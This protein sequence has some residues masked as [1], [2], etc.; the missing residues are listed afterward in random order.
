M[1]DRTCSI[2]GCER[3]Y[4]AHGWCQ[5]HYNRSRKHGDPSA[6]VPIIGYSRTANFWAKVD[7][8]GPVPAH[9]PDLGPCWVWTAARHG[10]G[11]GMFSVDRKRKVRAHRFAYEMM[12]GPIPE[13]LDLDHLC[14]NRACVNPE[15]LE[16]VT[17]SVNLK[18]GNVGGRRV[19]RERREAA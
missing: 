10:K 6:G 19:P 3:R 2:E 15:H 7:K 11:Y 16:P 17:R 1:A 14:R 9:R 8:H 18:R 5:A 4:Y 12:V 13:G